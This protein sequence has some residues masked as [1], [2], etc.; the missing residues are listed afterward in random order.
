MSSFSKGSSADILDSDESFKAGS[1][2]EFPDVE[3]SQVAW[4][5]QSRLGR[6]TATVLGKMWRYLDFRD[7]LKPGDEFGARLGLQKGEP[8]VRQ[9]VPIHL[10]AAALWAKTEE[11]R[12]EEVE[13]L[14]LKIREDL[15]AGAVT[16]AASLADAPP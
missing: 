6:G 11:P 10:A 2:A 3:L 13:R 12:W 8:E 4:D 5:G 16:A 1:P 15:W 9:C 7:E 14:A